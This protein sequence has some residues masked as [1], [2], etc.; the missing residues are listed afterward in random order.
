MIFT[1]CFN[2]FFGFL[3]NL[4]VYEVAHF[5][6]S[7]VGF[8]FLLVIL[9]TFNFS[10]FFS[11]V[12]FSFSFKACFWGL[13]WSCIFG[14]CT[15]FSFGICR[16]CFMLVGVFF[17]IFFYDLVLTFLGV[18]FSITWFFSMLRPFQTWE[19]THKQTSDFV[20]NYS[21]QPSHK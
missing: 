14:L 18:F 13:F 10:L 3:C 4:V 8:F 15:R 11:Q 21:C 6:L 12:D 17:W 2:L 1:F 9:T 16:V 19:K 7:F 5:F 20:R